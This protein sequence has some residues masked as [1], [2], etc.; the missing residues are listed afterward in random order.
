MDVQYHLQTIYDVMNDAYMAAAK[1]VDPD[2]TEDD[3]I[4]YVA[5]Y[6]AK[7]QAAIADLY[8]EINEHTAMIEWF[9]YAKAQVEAGVDP[10]T[11]WAEICQLYLDFQNQVLA[12]LKVQLDLAQK[13]YDD[14]MAYIN[15]KAAT[16][17]D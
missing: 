5:A 1:V 16:A 15:A 10:Y 2:A 17:E 9:T 4:E 12:D 6:K 13:D 3:L 11:Q 7:I 14:V 8:D